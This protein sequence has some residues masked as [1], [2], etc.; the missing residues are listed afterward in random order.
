MMM[1]D[2]LD[3]VD[4][5]ELQEEL[6]K[7]MA[8]Y[9]EREP[10][11]LFDLLPQSGV[12][13]PAPEDLSDEEIGRKLWEVLHGLSLCGVFL[14]NTDHLSDRELYIYLWRDALREPTVL[15]PENLSYSCHLDPIGSGSEEHTQLYLKYYASEEDRRQWRE[16][17]PED[18]IPASEK[19]PYDRDRRLPRAEERWDPPVA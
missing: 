4:D 3:D 17:W 10:S 13:L 18:H 5:E 11:S 12:S 8:A 7:H 9:G 14:H 1:P 16:D 6:L 15:M 19:P 2:D